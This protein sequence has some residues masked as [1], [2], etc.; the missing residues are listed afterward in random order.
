MIEYKACTK[1]HQELPIERFRWYP[2]K[3]YRNARCKT[4]EN[5]AQNEW[6]KKNKNRPSVIRTT[7]NQNLRKYNLTLDDYN[8]MFET[9][10]GVC[11]ICGKPEIKRM[12]SVDHNHETGKV[13]KLLCTYCNFRISIIEDKEFMSKANLYLNVIK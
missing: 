9:Q 4:C 10:N 11:A 7:R 12:L 6:K 13:R 2:K 1:C 5:K 3:Q 8:K